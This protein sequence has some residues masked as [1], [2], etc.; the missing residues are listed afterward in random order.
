MTLPLWVGDRIYLLADH[1]GIGNLYS[2]LP[3][4]EDLRRHAGDREFYLRH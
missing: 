4:G 1:E 2:C 3:N